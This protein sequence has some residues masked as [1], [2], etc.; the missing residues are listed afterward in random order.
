MISSSNAN[1]EFNSNARTVIR[2]LSRN[3]SG[4]KI[5]HLNVQS[6][7]KKIDEFRYIFE[8][9]EVDVICISETWFRSDMADS[10]FKVN[11]YKLL[12]S[13]RSSHGG[14]VAIYIRSNI[15]FKFV[16]K[17]STD[18]QI[19]YLFLEICT[20]NNKML[21]GS[22]YRPN[23][24]IDISTFISFLEDLCLPYNN[25]V[26]AGDFNCNLLL[27]S[28]LSTEMCAL[29]LY[30][31]NVLFPTHFSR[32]C[33]TLLDLF[34]VND[35]SKLLLYD[36]L[37]CPVFSKHDLIFLTYDFNIKRNPNIE[38]Y[39][40][41]YK[42]VNYVDLESAINNIDWNMIYFLSSPDDQVVFLQNNINVLFETHI[43]L[44]KVKNN[45]NKPW[46]SSKIQRYICERNEAYSRWKRYK[47]P[48]L[49]RVFKMLR[50]K[51]NMEISRAKSNYYENK[52]KSII[53]SKKTWK[54]IK[55]LGV[56]N[57]NC[58]NNLSA[59]DVNDL[60]EKFINISMPATNRNYY[61]NYTIPFRFNSVFRFSCIN[62]LD[63]VKHFLKIKSNAIGLDK[64][65][66]IFIKS[67]L[68]KLLPFLV[69]IFNTILTTSSFPK[70]WKKAKII[71]VEKTSNEYRPI[72]I[73]PYISKVF[74]SILHEQ[75]NNFLC[76]N[77]IINEF[78]SGYR[79][80]HGCITALLNV[81]EDIRQQLDLN[82]ITFL[83]LLDH[84][85]AFD[86]LDPEMLCM[87]L[88]T[89][90]NF[91]SE[92]VMLISNY[93]HHRSQ[94]VIINER[95]SSTCIIKRGVPQGSV[96]GPLLFSLY[97]NDLP[98]VLKFCKIHLY[99][100]D[101][102]LYR[103][104]SATDI[105][106]GT[107]QVNQ[108]LNAVYEWAS[109]NG[110][111]LN[112][113]KS[114]AI[115]ISRIKLDYRNI[116]DI[117]LRNIPIEYVNKIK[118]L[119]II[120]N[121]DLSWTDHI[122]LTIG[123]VYGRL[124]TLWVTQSFTP[125]KIR[126][127]LAK[128]YL[129]PTLMYGCE[130]YANCDSRDKYKLNKLY[131]NIARYIFC[132][133]KYDRIS[134]FSYEICS[135]SFDNLLK[136]RVVIFLHKIIISMMPPY[137]FNKLSFTLSHRHKNIRTIRTHYLISERQFLIFAIRLWNSLPYQLTFI[138]NPVHF[139]NKLKKLLSNNNNRISNI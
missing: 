126:M 36:Q 18:S 84:S 78:Q 19:E 23:R 129:L 10:L 111:S 7:V 30:S 123:K 74:E 44:K 52:F 90:Y 46:F 103:S 127:L 107:I 6:L 113:T 38:F 14:G 22:V 47:I 75:I 26:I 69:H 25:V 39:Y 93:L 116:P 73:L 115:V 87:K 81:S 95:K 110:L 83:T 63:V 112:P 114:K 133:R 120:F 45:E 132:I 57:N 9:S 108:D 105:I 99:A 134:M 89:F 94:A 1:S 82:K 11:G 136:F 138:T 125:L 88:S 98:Y 35:L 2:L 17:S 79:A 27:E 3:K 37:S 54:T 66:P 29:G 53:S 124:R 109:A 86:T 56:C 59:I 55:E 92:A 77:N 34:F 85:K 8:K 130:I 80:N 33:N 102:Q 32:N 49:H 62:E 106:E 122:N 48:E 131:N 128:V 13:D 12:R 50:N 72:A 91:S 135:M 16:N 101:V 121:R 51:V 21:I 100:D 68:P 76:H 5:C 119:G 61:E 137:L 70:I 20:E 24:T 64:I 71:P 42:N 58:D 28:Y 65:E 43:P 139:K 15:S 40:R 4:L 117:M 97:I 104:C 67:I 41:D 96:L 31:C 118:N 60:N